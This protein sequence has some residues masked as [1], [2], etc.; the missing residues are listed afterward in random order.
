MLFLDA[1]RRH[2]A[3]N[4]RTNCVA[5]DLHPNGTPIPRKTFGY[6]AMNVVEPVDLLVE[7]FPNH[8]SYPV[9]PNG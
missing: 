6:D 1:F 3:S 2:K 7:Q 5:F 4:A 8:L 9:A